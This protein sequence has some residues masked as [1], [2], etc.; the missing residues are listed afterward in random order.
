MIV[1]LWTLIL[2]TCILPLNMFQSQTH[3]TLVFMYTDMNRQIS[4]MKIILIWNS[5]RAKL[6]PIL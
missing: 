6:Y 4:N 1:L 5:L 3:L 2:Y